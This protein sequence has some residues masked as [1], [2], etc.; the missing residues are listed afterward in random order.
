MTPTLF[1]LLNAPGG[2]EAWFEGILRWLV[3]S[4]PR[5]AD[6]RRT[7]RL[8]DLNG[9][10]REHPRGPE[11]QARIRRVWSHTSAVRLLADTGLP[12]HTAFLREAAHRTVERFVPRLEPEADLSALLDRLGLGEEDAGWIRNL[13]PAA[14]EPWRDLLAL[15][16]EMVW[17]AAQLLAYRATALGLARDLLGLAPDERELDSPFVQLPETM[18]ALRRGEA[19]P[20]PELLADCRAR[21]KHSLDYLDRHGVSSELVYRLDL[22]A[23]HLGRMEELVNLA[24]G[25]VDGKAFAATLV[26]QAAEHHSLAGLLRSTNRRLARKVVEYT[27]QT[28]EHYIANTR[29]EWRGTFWSAAWGG[30]LTAFTAALKYGIAAATMAPMIAGL[31]FAGNYTASFVIMQFAGFTLASKQPAMTAASLAGALED[32]LPGQA[33]VDLVAG[34]ARSQF[35]ATVGNV[36]WTI[37]AALLLSLAW[38]RLTGHP[39]LSAASAEHSLEGLHPLRSWTLP[40]AALTGV[41]LWMSS[42]AAGWAANWSAFRHLPQALA[43]HRRVIYWLGPERAVWLGRLVERNLGGVCGYIALGFLLGFMPVVFAFMGLAVEVR[44]VTLSAASLALCAAQSFSSGGP[45]PW[46]GLAWGLAGIAGIGVLNFSVSF[47]LALRTAIDAR[48]LDRK[49]REGL[50]RLLWTAFRRHPWKFLGPPADAAPR[51]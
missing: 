45:V 39:L 38:G 40:F 13:A 18:A 27:G 24:A 1:L 35:M 11:W 19:A 25:R 49:G 17:D 23:T 30:V 12:V 46:V 31:A 51:P 34:I 21:L 42:L 22:L 48:G 4:S 26:C 8:L 20:W 37:P 41:F 43:G 47:M 36:V 32:R 33:M 28:G 2:D 3:D 15:P 16:P 29:A 9:V 10:L 5:G 14:A 6:A 44:H 7:R 50:R